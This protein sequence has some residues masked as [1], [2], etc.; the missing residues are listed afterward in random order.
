M[1]PPPAV[2]V[3]STAPFLTA[4]SMSRKA[5]L[6]IL[7]VSC[8]DSFSTVELLKIRMTEPIWVRWG[9]LAGE[10]RLES[11]ALPVTVPR[12]TGERTQA[13]PSHYGP[14]ESKAERQAQH[15]E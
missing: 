4:R 2:T 11:E 10:T 9:E 13:E 8:K 3:Q 6:D 14:G 5:R 1:L 7:R 12:A 15:Q